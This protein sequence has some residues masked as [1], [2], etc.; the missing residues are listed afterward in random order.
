M[1]GLGLYFLGSVVLG[2]ESQSPLPLDRSFGLPSSPLPSQSVLA[3]SLQYMV[4]VQL[5]TLN[6]PLLL[7]VILWLALSPPS[8]P[9]VVSGFLFLPI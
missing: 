2:T 9:P 5:M 7:P 1:A 3:F 8:L 6:C 4:Q